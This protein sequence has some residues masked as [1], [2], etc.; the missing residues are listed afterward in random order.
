MLGVYK[1]TSSLTKRSVPQRPRNMRLLKVS[2]KDLLLYPKGVTGFPYRKII[3][4]SRRAAH[5]CRHRRVAIAARPARPALATQ[6]PEVGANVVSAGLRLLARSLPSH[7]APANL[8]PLPLVWG[9]CGVVLLRGFEPHSHPR[10]ESSGVV[11]GGPSPPALARRVRCPLTRGL[12]WR[13]PRGPERCW[14]DRV[15]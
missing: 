10:T 6:P 8:R 7:N 2:I 5:V 3:L 12:G 13:R 11:W 9:V 14:L 1:T 4:L 15:A